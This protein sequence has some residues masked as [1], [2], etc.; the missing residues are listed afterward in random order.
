[1]TKHFYAEKRKSTLYHVHSRPPP[2]LLL[3]LAGRGTTPGNNRKNIL[4]WTQQNGCTQLN[5]KNIRVALQAKC[6][7]FRS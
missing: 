1:M 6:T 4:Y 3:Q 7:L 2:R 5:H